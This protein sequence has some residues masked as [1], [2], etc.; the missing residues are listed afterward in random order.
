MKGYTCELVFSPDQVTFNPSLAHTKEAGGGM[1]TPFYII[2]TMQV[3]NFFIL[4]LACNGYTIVMHQIYKRK[5][6]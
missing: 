1:Y 4:C 6:T 3:V 2:D 5:H